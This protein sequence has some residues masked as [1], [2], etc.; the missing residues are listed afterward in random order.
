MKM[1]NTTG[2]GIWKK[3]KRKQTFATFT[4]NVKVFCTWKS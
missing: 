1:K 2:A 3:G 4:Q